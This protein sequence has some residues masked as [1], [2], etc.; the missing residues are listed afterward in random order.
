MGCLCPK[1]QPPPAQATVKAQTVVVPAKP[2]AIKAIPETERALAP[3]DRRK[4]WNT[5]Y[6]K[7]LDR[8]DST[9]SSGLKN[10]KPT[11]NSNLSNMRTDTFSDGKNSIC[12]GKSK[13]TTITTKLSRVERMV[14]YV[15]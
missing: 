8:R 9:N 13:L 11:E 4:D 6:K 14:S 15:S 5:A 10:D 12:G 2:L 1:S 7:R 3:L